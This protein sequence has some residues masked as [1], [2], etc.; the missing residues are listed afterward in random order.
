MYGVFAMIRAIDLRNF[1]H[2]R[3]YIWILVTGMLIGVV[4]LIDRH[5]ITDDI[6]NQIRQSVIEEQ[7]LNAIKVYINYTLVYAIYRMG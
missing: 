5:S 6:D 1:E 3:K 2:K 7:R 4:L